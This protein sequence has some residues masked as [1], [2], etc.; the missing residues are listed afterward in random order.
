M[1]SHPPAAFFAQPSNPRQRR[2][3]ILRA[4]FFEGLTAQQVA[5]RFGCAVSS[6]YA[7]TRDFR[8][9]D[10]PAAFFF[11]LPDA[12]GRPPSQ[13][14]A[15]LRQRVI[16]LRKA[17]L[18]LPDIK[19]RLDAESD[20]AASLRMIGNILDE[21]GFARLPRRSRAERAAGATPR[22]RAPESVLLDPQ[23]SAEFQSER[24]AG[25]LCLLP[26]IRHYGLDSAIDQA[27]YPGTSCLPALQSVLAFVALKLSDVR[28]YSADDLWCMDRGPGLFAG[29]NVLPKTASLSSYADRTTRAM[30][31]RLLAALAA[32]WSAKGLVGDSANLDFTSLPHW[33]D[34]AT[35]E[36]HWSGTRGRAL[37]SISAA[38]AQDPDSGLLLHSDAAIRSAS[39]HEAVLEFL[40]FSRS[41]GPQLR[42]LVF[43]SRFTTYAQLAQ[44]DRQDIRFVTVRRRGQALVAK[45][46]ALPKDAWRS[47]RV[48]TAKA[49]RLVSAHE[50]TVPLHGFGEIRQITILRGSQ[51]RPV[52]LITNDFDSS[53]SAILRRYA[54]RWLV[55]QSISEQLA[56]FHLNRLPSSMV[57]KV[58]FDLAMTVLAY[59]LLRLLAL[60]LPPGYQRLTPRSLYERLLCNGADIAL[61]PNRCTVSLKKKRDLPALLHALQA[62][63]SPAIPWLGNRQLVFQGATRS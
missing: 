39:K 16:E 14:P 5:R 2:Y 37:I 8:R 15:D 35:L 21:E 46:R 45:A 60:D 32:I 59:N 55:E 41:H 57:I 47:V 56:F 62:V 50:Q 9:L 13:P 43:D 17:N 7:M 36:K 4:F 49:T 33:G 34:D 20:H 52:L 26:W 23:A 24:A 54:R 19:A 30:H 38:L 51:R 27:G 63:G 42:Y 18:S 25:M 12:P 1:S 40:D 22:L 28:R 3:E 48:P 10:D 58:D 44:L 6:V 53:L 31:Q 11:R 61:T 29:L